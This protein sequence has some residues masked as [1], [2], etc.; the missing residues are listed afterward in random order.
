MTKSQKAYKSKLIKLIQ[1][2]KNNVFPDDESR[3]EFMK[4]RFNCTSTKELS[5]DQLNHLLNFCLRKIND[6][7]RADPITS[8]QK[9][10]IHQQ[11]QDKARDKQIN[12]L[13]S[14]VY[15]ITQKDDIE[16]LTKEEATKVII[17]LSKMR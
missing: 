17:A 1:I 2:N 9:Q 11:W 7:P 14:F 15:R 5:I 10:K 4:S 13:L 8:A 3:R 12:A 6:I 16:L